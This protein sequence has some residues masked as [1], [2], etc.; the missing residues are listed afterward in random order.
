MANVVY[1]SSSI[2][3]NNN[4]HSTLATPSSCNP[5]HLPSTHTGIV[6][7]GASGFYFLSSAPISN[8][9]PQAP[10]VG[11]RV[12]K[13]LPEKSVASGILP[14]VPSLPPAAIQGHVMPSFPHTLI[15]V[16]P[17][18]DLGC[19]IR[20]TKTAVTIVDPDGRCILK[21]W[22]ECDSPRLWR[23][24]LK[25]AKPS[26]P[27]PM[28]HGTHEESG[29][30]PSD[31]NFSQPMPATPINEATPSPSVPPPGASRGGPDKRPQSTFCISAKTSMPLAHSAK[32]ALSS[33][34]TG[35]HRP[36]PWRPESPAQPLTPA[37]WISPALAP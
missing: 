22:R 19:A 5:T 24:P 8:L 15:G 6:D 20:F 27:V 1:C 25:A 23:F 14:L 2:L 31:A 16:G 18:A 12:A 17:F 30:R 21:S 32:P 9:N 3:F 33:T 10:T 28:A 34:S 4:Y 37:A 36:W 29:P 26:L 13:G 35:P 11:A 7:S